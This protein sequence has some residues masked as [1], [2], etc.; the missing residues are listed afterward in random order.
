MKKTLLIIAALF[1]ICS[2]LFVRGCF[3]CVA[4]TDHSHDEPV[5]HTNQ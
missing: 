1:I 4:G 5:Q 3:H 2:F